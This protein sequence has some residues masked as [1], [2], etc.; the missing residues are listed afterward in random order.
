MKWLVSI[1]DT[2]I[3]IWSVLAMLRFLL[4]KGGLS[5]NH[6]SAYFLYRSTQWIVGEMR[7]IIQPIKGWDMA[8]P[9]SVFLI[10]LLYEFV[11]LLINLLHI[12]IDLNIPNL[13]VGTLLIVILKVI[14]TSVYAFLYELIMKYLL[15]HNLKDIRLLQAC[16]FSINCI[17][18]PFHIR[19]KPTLVAF[20]FCIVWV[21]LIYPNLMYVVQRYVLIQ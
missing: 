7:K 16:N 5:Y 3:F 6:P 8:I 14:S 19:Y 20:V 2:L 10:F 11:K 17:L 9:V 21:L 1:L 13:V 18:S 4:Q 15:Q 12:N